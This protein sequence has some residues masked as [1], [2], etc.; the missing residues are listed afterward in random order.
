MCCASFSHEKIPGTVPYSLSAMIKSTTLL[1]EVQGETVKNGK[2][3]VYYTQSFIHLTLEPPPSFQQS[4]IYPMVITLMSIPFIWT[5]FSEKTE[6]KNNKS[7]KRFSHWAWFIS[8]KKEQALEKQWQQK[9]EQ[10]QQST[11]WSMWDNLEGHPHK[12]MEQ[13]VS[14]CGEGS[15][16]GRRGTS[17]LEQEIV[18]RVRENCEQTSLGVIG[19]AITG[20]ET[21]ETA[22][23]LVSELK[24]IGLKAAFSSSSLTS[25]RK[26]SSWRAIIWAMTMPGCIQP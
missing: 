4:L 6:K 13:S 3:K 1:R 15:S 19:K 11:E 8:R 20:A 21:I 10:W 5:L 23:N 25:G 22:S 7:C 17:V 18:P 24:P 16:A 12:A 9:A 26:L 14:V 2:E